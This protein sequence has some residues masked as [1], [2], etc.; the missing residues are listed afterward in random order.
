[1]N[2]FKA[3]KSIVKFAEATTG[4]HTRCRHCSCLVE[5]EEYEKNANTNIKCGS[6]GHLLNDHDQY[7]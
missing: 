7:L 6:C 3:I 1:M 5:N 4:G 2:F